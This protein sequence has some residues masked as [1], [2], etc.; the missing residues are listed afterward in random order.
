[1]SA[2]ARDNVE[3]HRQLEVFRDCVDEGEYQAAGSS[4]EAILELV[5]EQAGTMDAALGPFEIA[6]ILLDQGDWGGVE[7]IYVQLLAD[8][9]ADQ[10]VVFR[11]H[12]YL[13]WLYKVLERHTEALC[14]TQAAIAAMSGIDLP[15]AHQVSLKLQESELYLDLEM[16]DE[17]ASIITSVVPLREQMSEHLWAN[18][19]IVNARYHVVIGQH[20]EAERDLTEAYGILSRMSCMPFAGGVHFDLATYWAVAA[21]L[22]NAVGD[23]GKAIEAW[24]QAVACCRRVLSFPH[25]QGAMN[26]LSLAR[27][28][29]RLSLAYASAG[30]NSRAR[31]ML[32]ESDALSKEVNI[33]H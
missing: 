24:E 12:S 13:A 19:L 26:T 4:L 8:P 21:G 1:M 28:L 9:T 23:S 6:D 22:R 25:T 32:Q 29:A 2:N 30:E 16:P 15:V 7:A 17:A 3:L 31:R 11:A 18:V 33:R 20:N 10:T 5:T 14:H 27:M